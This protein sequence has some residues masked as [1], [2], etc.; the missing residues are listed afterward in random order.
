ME[1]GWKGEE[2]RVGRGLNA[3]GDRFCRG[4]YH[5]FKTKA[6]FSG[7][8]FFAAARLFVLFLNERSNSLNCC[9]MDCL[10]VPVP[11]SEYDAGI[12]QAHW[13]LAMTKGKTPTKTNNKEDINKT[14]QKNKIEE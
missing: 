12:I 1:E 5:H 6:H 9:D 2:G 3:R 8:Q 11:V 14:E 4:K 7:T 10:N 13:I